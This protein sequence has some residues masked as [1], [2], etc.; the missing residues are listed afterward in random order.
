MPGLWGNWVTTDHSNWHGDF[1]L[2][3]NFQAPFYGVYA[4][5][6][7][8]LSLP[9]YQAILE[10]VPNGRLMAKRHG[11]KGVHL[12]T[13]IGPWGLSPEDS[14]KDLGQRSDAAF[15]ALNFI[16]EYQYTQ[17]TDFLRTTAYPFLAMSV[18]SG[19][20]T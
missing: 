9:F 8:D 12:P 10:S 2:N 6:H 1:H 17:D 19:K 16:W 15:A 20:T 5:N 3:Y 13:C 4:S 18:T 7:A 14:D 11:W